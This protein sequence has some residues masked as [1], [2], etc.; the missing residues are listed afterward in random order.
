MGIC[1]K[2]LAYIF[3]PVIWRN[4]PTAKPKQPYNYILDRALYTDT[5]KIFILRPEPRDGSNERLK[6]IN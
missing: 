4:G 2:I 6:T 5:T 1:G 3:Y